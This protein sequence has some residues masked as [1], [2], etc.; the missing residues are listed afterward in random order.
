MHCS[1]CPNRDAGANM[2]RV[3]LYMFLEVADIPTE[4]QKLNSLTRIPYTGVWV[5]K[6][7]EAGRLQTS[8]AGVF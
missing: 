8:K 6:L 2:S 5:S 3:C 4:K 1:G 7:E